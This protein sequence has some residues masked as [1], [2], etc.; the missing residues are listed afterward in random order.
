MCN[1]KIAKRELIYR[2]GK[3]SRKEQ[4]KL[5][6]SDSLSRSVKERIELGFIPMKIPVIDDV[7]YRIFNTMREYRKWANRSLPK[8]LGYYKVND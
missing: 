6:F 2:I 5:D 3:L 1:E 7:P 4:L 8:W